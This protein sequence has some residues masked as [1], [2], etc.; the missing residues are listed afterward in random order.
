MFYKN[1]YPTLV[2][3]KKTHTVQKAIRWFIKNEIEFRE[4]D[5][6][7]KQP[8]FIE[9]DN[10][11]R[12]SEDGTFTLLSKNSNAYK[13]KK[14]L[15]DSMNYSEFVKYICANPYLLT[16]NLIV[17]GQG[18]VITGFKEEEIRIFLRK[19]VKLEIR[20]NLISKD[21]SYLLESV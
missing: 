9:I 19:K 10:I 7:Q 21:L 5:F 6:S 3:F 16:T 1:N 4:R 14:Y 11:I 20:K 17:I 13:S 12:N 2:Y 8:T 15:I 18:K